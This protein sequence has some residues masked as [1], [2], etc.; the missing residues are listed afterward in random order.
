V[1]HP[2]F[3][4]QFA[5]KRASDTRLIDLTYASDADGRHCR[6]CHRVPGSSSQTIANES[7]RQIGASCRGNSAVTAAQRYSEGDS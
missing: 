5:L 1:A 4:A 6:D 3:P 2:F 7:A